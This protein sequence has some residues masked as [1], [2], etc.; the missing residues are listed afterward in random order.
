L[1]WRA[2]GIKRLALASSA[3]PEIRRPKVKP[4]KIPRPASWNWGMVFAVVESVGK[5]LSI[6]QANDGRFVEEADLPGG[7]I[8]SSLEP[9]GRH[10]PP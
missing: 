8:P 1:V 4:G 5:L 6:R 9:R 2:S 7:R 3:K 10:G